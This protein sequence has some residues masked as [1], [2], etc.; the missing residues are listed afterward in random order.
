MTKETKPV[1]GPVWLKQCH[2]PP[3]GDN[4]DDLGMVYGIVLTTLFPLKPP[5]SRGFP[6]I[7]PHKK[8]P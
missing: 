7:C 1:S 6:S 3:H 2:K 5:F 8:S 4:L